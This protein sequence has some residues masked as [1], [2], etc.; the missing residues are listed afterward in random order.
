MQTMEIQA[1]MINAGF[2]KKYANWQGFLNDPITDELIKLLLQ[3]GRLE[4]I[5]AFC[6]LGEAP[7]KAVVYDIEDFAKEHG[8][9]ENGKIDDEWKRNVGRLIGAIVAFFGY[10][11]SGEENLQDTPKYFQNAARY[12]KK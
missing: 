12:N 2:C 10:E 7:L 1:E 4:K 5:I 9:V 11:R 8:K 6:E 3:D